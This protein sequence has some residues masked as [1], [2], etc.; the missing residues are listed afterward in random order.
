MVMATQQK[1]KE[2]IQKKNIQEIVINSYLDYTLIKNQKPAS[3][4]AFCK[5]LEIS[6]ADF[7]EYFNTFEAI[8]RHMWKSYADE[9]IDRLKSDEVFQTYSVREKTL[10]FFYT[11]C[12]MLK[13]NRSYVAHSFSSIKKSDLNPDQLKEFKETVV[14]YFKSRLNDGLE[15]GE[16]VDRKKISQK[17]VDAAWVQ[18]LFLTQFWLK[19][20]SKNFENTDAAIEKSVNVAFDLAGK[21]PLESILDFGKFLYQNR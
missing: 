18:F 13:A 11:L 6:E 2:K 5:D 17:Y 1:N 20:N 15:S 16:I 4:F 21:S 14:E 12:E 19:D 3:V 9:T 8:D 7:Y 10:A